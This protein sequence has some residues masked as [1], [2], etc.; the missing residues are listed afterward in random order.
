MNKASKL[1]VFSLLGSIGLT[2]TSQ[3]SAYVTF[4]YKY[5]NTPFQMSYFNDC[6]TYVYNGTSINFYSAVQS[7]VSSWNN[8][9]NTKV[10]M[11]Q[12]T[13]QAQSVMDFHNQDVG[14]PSVLGQTSFWNNATKVDPTTTNW[15][16]TRVLMNQNAD[17]AY[18]AQAALYKDMNAKAR[19]TAAH[20]EGHA[21]GLNHAPSS[22]ALMYGTSA[23]YVYYNITTPQTDDVAGVQGIYGTLK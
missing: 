15:Y 22:T 14:D 1:F 21:L 10:L 9:S 20:E 2:I 17:W 18:F 6:S 7:G 8:T 19:Y 4:G 11:N 16:W 12:T 3:A 5:T 23:P 13:T